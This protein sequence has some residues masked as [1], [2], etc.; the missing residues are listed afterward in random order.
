MK[1]I[2]IQS[3][4]EFDA[5]DIAYINITSWKEAYS[6]ILPPQILDSLSVEKSAFFWKVALQNNAIVLKITLNEKIIGFSFLCKNKTPINSNAHRG[7]INAIYL[8][9][10][11]WRKGFGKQL[12]LA[13]LSELKKLGFKK[14]IVWTLSENNRA[15]NFYK[16][17]GFKRSGASRICKIL[18]KSNLIEIQF[19]KS[20]SYI[21]EEIS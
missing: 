2:K 3:A 21:D 10:N 8:D 13:S 19:I 14:A 6:T 7:E 5:Y 9:P 20:L 18:P 1:R 4:N 17:L 12:C 16:S 15:I 11:K